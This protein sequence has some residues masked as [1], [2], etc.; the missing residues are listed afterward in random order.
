MFE[1]RTRSPTSAIMVYEVLFEALFPLQVEARKK[2]QFFS[3]RIMPDWTAITIKGGIN[4]TFII[5][6]KSLRHRSSS[7]A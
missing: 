1:E 5:K 6:K 7:C 2:H 3:Y 4:V